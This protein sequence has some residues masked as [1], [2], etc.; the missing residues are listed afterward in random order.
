M[1]GYEQD[2]RNLIRHAFVFA[3]ILLLHVAA[4]GAFWIGLAD[5]GVRYAQTIFQIDVVPDVKPKEPPPP[6]PPVELESQEVSVDAAQIDID[7]PVA[8][9]LT[10]PIQVT[11]VPQEPITPVPPLA[12]PAS[13]VASPAATVRPHPIYVPGGR[14]RYPA[15]SIRAGE[16]GTPTI[17][18]CVSATGAVDSV[19]MTQTSGFPRLDQA[20]IGIGNEARFKPAR[21]DGK[22]VPLCVLY[23]VKFAMGDS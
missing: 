8:E 18:I 9:E 20:A 4:I 3:G 1:N 22:P 14:E 5:S 6:L 23:R 16:T 21:R 7:I 19:Q 17:T 12:P 15:D 11:R 13:P 2:P 10:P